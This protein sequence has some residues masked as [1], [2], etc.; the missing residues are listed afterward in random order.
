MKKFGML[1]MTFAIMLFITVAT[2][3]ATEEQEMG[4]IQNVQLSSEGELTFD[5]FE[6]AD[7]YW[8]GLNHQSWSIETGQSIVSSLQTLCEDTYMSPYCQTTDPGTYFFELEAKNG[9]NTI[10]TSYGFVSFN[11][12][13]FSLT[14]ASENHYIL[15]FNSNGGSGKDPMFVPVSEPLERPQPPEKGGTTF[16]GW[17]KDAEFNTKF[18]F[19]PAS[20]ERF[21]QVLYAKWGDPVVID[22]VEFDG[23]KLPVDGEHPEAE[24]FRTIVPKTEGVRVIMASWFDESS[25]NE[26]SS[27]DTFVKG[28]KYILSVVV[29]LEDGYVF[30][31]GPDFWLEDNTTLNIEPIPGMSSYITERQEFQFRFE[32][33]EAEVPTETPTEPT[34]PGTTEPVV[35]P[36][37]VVVGPNLDAFKVSSVKTTSLKLSWNKVSEAKGYIVYT[38]TNNKKWT[39]VKTI[40]K[41]S[42]TSYTVKKLKAGTTHYYKVVAYK[43]V[44]KKNKTV[45]TSKVIKVV[46]VPA[47]PKLKVKST[48]FNSVKLNVASVKGAKSYVIEKSTDK[49]NWSSTVTATK[50]G[51]ITI[52]GLNTGTK[53]Y[54]RVKACNDKCSGNSKVVSAKPALKAPSIKVKS[55]TKGQVKITYKNV[56]GAEVYEVYRS[57]KKNGKYTLVGSE[58]ALQYVDAA[59]S[60]K[61]YY[62]KVRATSNVNGKIVG[63]Y[64]KAVKV[65]VK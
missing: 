52:D 9:D 45:V 46:T 48:T 13:A 60:K 47:T 8:L 31:E 5:D 35:N 40:T 63:T 64:S 28:K 58:N 20:M 49:K 23:A 33:K 37:P 51:N 30:K 21:Y 25:G 55:S 50:A 3:N 2:V 22:A 36:T 12:T 18:D 14:P 4:H 26:L 19:S 41:N 7:S 61:T 65:K 11:G 6:G 42:T 56:T 57:T 16:L 32:A 24:M 29:E 27:S 10:A 54:F 17:Y 59:K 62:Y 38:S 53:Y 39:K 1:L 43:V 34:T 15:V 44:K